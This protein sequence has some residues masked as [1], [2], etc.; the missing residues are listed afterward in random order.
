MDSRFLRVAYAIEFLAALCA[1]YVTWSEVGGQA[2]LDYMEWYA[3]LIPGVL[4]A[5]LIVK[6]TAA[7]VRAETPWSGGTLRWLSAGLIL[8]ALMAAMTYYEH[9]NE[10]PPDDG[11]EE[12]YTLGMLHRK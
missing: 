10:P 7:S 6:A 5:W 12:T 3:K 8:I 9:L 2:H 1:V 4:L 11:E